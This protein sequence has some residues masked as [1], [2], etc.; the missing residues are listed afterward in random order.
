MAIAPCSSARSQSPRGSPEPRSGRDLAI[1]LYFPEEVGAATWHPRANRTSYVSP[2]GDHAGRAVWIGDLAVRSW[3]VLCGLDVEV[4]KPA[5]A[6][7]ALGDSLTDGDGSTLDAAATWPEVLA[8]RLAKAG[9]SDVAIINAGIAGNRLIHDDPGFRGASALSRFDRDVLAVLGAR[10]VI[11]LEGMNDIGSPRLA[12]APE[13]AVGVERLIEAYRRIAGR[14]HAAGLRIIVGTL[15]PFEGSNHA[16]GQNES[17]RRQVN[18]WLRRSAGEPGAF[19]AV[20]DFD[21]V[22]S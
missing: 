6:V 19:D 8:L 10:I 12:Q 2:P 5:I 4:P 11:L 3:Y 21:A 13:E 9:R 1:D 15:P 18:D 16:G 14:A 17:K 7:V 22:L 20:I